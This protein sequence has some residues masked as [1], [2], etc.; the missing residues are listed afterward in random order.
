MTAKPSKKKHSANVNMTGRCVTTCLAGEKYTVKE[1][2]VLPIQSLVKLCVSYRFLYHD[3]LLPAVYAI[4]IHHTILQAS[5]T[6]IGKPELVKLAFT[7][8]MPASECQRC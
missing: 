4:A 1:E 5:S 7:G 6:C 8:L 2:A 3:I